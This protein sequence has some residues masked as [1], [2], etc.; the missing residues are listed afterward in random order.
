MQ[1]DNFR[2]P[3]D[4]TVDELKNWEDRGIYTPGST[5]WSVN[6]QGLV[7]LFHLNEGEG[8]DA[9]NRAPVDTPIDGVITD[10]G[11]QDGPITKILTFNGSS[12]MVSLGDDSK[13]GI[14]LTGKLSFGGW[15][16]PSTTDSTERNVCHKS[17]QF[18][19]HYHSNTGVVTASITIGSTVH[20]FNSDAGVATVGARLF[21][22]VTYDGATREN[23][24]E[25]LLA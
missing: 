8:T 14:N 17:G 16:S 21:V 2:K 19:L 5:S 1:L 22:M 10:G 4:A 20:Y 18:G 6:L 12:S 23:V 25:W 3:L 24:C 7:G 9:K 15:F 11:W 13:A